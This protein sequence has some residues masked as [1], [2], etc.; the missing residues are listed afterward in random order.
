MIRTE[1][2][3]RRFDGVTAVDDLTLEVEVGVSHYINR[4]P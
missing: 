4:L 2:L 3:T 1:R